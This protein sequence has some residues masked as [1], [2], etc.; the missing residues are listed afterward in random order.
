M[1][2]IIKINF[3]DEESFTIYYLTNEIYENEEDFKLLFKYIN[4]YLDNNYDF[5]F[6]GIYD[7]CIYYDKGIYILDF[8][9]DSLYYN[10]DFNV[11]L[12]LN[13]VILYEFEDIDLINNQIIYYNEK[14]YTEIKN[15]I[16]D[17]RLF[18]YG[19]IIYGKEVDTILNKGIL[20]S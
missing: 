13:T 16:N 5:S 1:K 10:N 8:D 2:D 3:K 19:R 12:L 4:N 17:I 11:T 18:E 7:V 15:I 6:S 9:F 14:F 20:L